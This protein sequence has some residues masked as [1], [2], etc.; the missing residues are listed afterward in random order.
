MTPHSP[1]LDTALGSKERLQPHVC[2][3][4]KSVSIEMV[5]TVKMLSIFLL[6]GLVTIM[7]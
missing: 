1:H 4:L 3:S 2:F 6:K 5:S 7:L